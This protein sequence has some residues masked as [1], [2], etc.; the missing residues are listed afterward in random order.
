MVIPF[1]RARKAWATANRKPGGPCLIDRLP[2]AV[3]SPL[4][5]VNR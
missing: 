4:A 3:D 1:C 5:R 2:Y